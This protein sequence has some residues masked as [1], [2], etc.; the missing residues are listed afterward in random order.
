MD[1][2]VVGTTFRGES[3][4]KL[5][6]KGAVAFEREPDN[7][8]DK[9]AI[10][11]VWEGHNLGY[12]PKAGAAQKKIGA[13]IDSKSAIKAFILK[14]SYIDANN[15]WNNDHEG[16]LQSVSVSFEEAGNAKKE[17][18]PQEK[19]VDMVS[20]NEG[21]TVNFKEIQHTYSLG[22]KRLTGITT[23]IK[24]YIKGF[25]KDR[26][27][28]VC[29][30]AWGIDESVIEAAWELGGDLAAQF[31]TS[32]HKALEYELKYRSHKKK[33]DE[34][35]AFQIKHP[36]ISQYVEDFFVMYDGLGFKG[37]V[38]PEAL[39]TNV[40]KGVCA[41][42]DSLLVID[43]KKKICRLQDYKVNHSIEK[44]GTTSF[45][46]LPDG[47]KLPTNKLSKFSLQ[48]SGQAEILEKSGWTVQGYDVFV[49]EDIWKHYE[50]ER[51]PFTI[52]T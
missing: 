9:D 14:Y 4:H 47:I 13:L 36:I 12:V 6:P 5:R 3:I 18:A 10:R 48:L 35:R 31:G 38:V 2:N 51:I 44:A 45:K 22:D 17:G 25:D 27:I 34:S 8:Y 26:M 46:G 24:K 40:D 30:N 15:N 21:V 39:V 23:H 33:K 43:E 49:L 32:I 1:F 20:F 41:L 37:E 16:I 19:G 52:I 29:S 50:I 28:P 11:V 42:V 7:K